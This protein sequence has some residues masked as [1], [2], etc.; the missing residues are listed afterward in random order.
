M[1]KNV[2]NP[3]LPTALV[4]IPKSV[5]IRPTASPNPRAA[6]ALTLDTSG[7]M[8]GD[9]IEQLNGGTKLLARSL[10]S[11]RLSAAD[12]EVACVGVGG[13]FLGR[14]E[15]SVL[16]DFTPAAA[17][18]PPELE[19][20]GGTPLGR[21]LLTTLAVIARRQAVY[22]ERDLLYHP[23]T[24][25]L[26]TDGWES[27][28]GDEFVRAGDVLR[29]LERRDAVRFYPV[30]VAGADM[31]RLATLSIRPPYTLD[32][33]EFDRFFDWLARS[34]RQTSRSVP[35]DGFE[36]A[37]PAAAGVAGRYKG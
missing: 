31:D 11:D 28:S 13:G 8:I 22:R 3:C 21:G 1:A 14:G 20:G 15:V 24:L 23:P 19:A 35:G 27:E 32:A 4:P 36:P 33:V 6:V 30:G 2:R 16:S 29:D 25:V 7:S 9:K 10:Q 34:A 5:P 37:D 18:Q 17:W 26:I 12:I